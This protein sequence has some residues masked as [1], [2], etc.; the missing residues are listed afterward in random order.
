VIGF[1]AMI[2]LTAAANLMLKLGIGMSRA[3]RIVFG[4][5]GWK[6]VAGLALF[7]AVGCS[8]PC[9]CAESLSTSLRDSHQR[10]SSVSLSLR[11]D[12][13]RADLTG[14]LDRDRLYLLRDPVGRTNGARLGPRTL[15]TDVLVSTC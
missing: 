6:S 8:T 12:P 15:W 5:L 9:Y 11:L 2:S 3:E 10:R 14:A 1:A 13:G 7:D 4:L